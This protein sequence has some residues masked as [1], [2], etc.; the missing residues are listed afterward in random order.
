[1]QVFPSE[2]VTITEYVTVDVCDAVGDAI[3]VYP[4]PVEGDQTYVN[5]P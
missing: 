1:M 3:V 2:S 4:S 5:G